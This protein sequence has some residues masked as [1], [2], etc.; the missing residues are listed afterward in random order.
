KPGTKTKPGQKVPF[1]HIGKTLHGSVSFV[2]KPDAKQ[3]AAFTQ[4]V[5]QNS[6]YTPETFRHTSVKSACVIPDVVGRPCAIK[7]VLYIIRENRTYDQVFGDMKDTAGKPIGNG[8]PK[9]TL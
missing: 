7:Y 5:R 8:D 2:A 9:L 3:M 6:P 4:Q 1:D